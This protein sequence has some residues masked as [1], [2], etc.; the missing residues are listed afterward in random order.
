M[1]LDSFCCLIGANS[2]NFLFSP[3]NGIALSVIKFA[4][5]RSEIHM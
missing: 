5:I 4:A 2:F 3:P 1:A